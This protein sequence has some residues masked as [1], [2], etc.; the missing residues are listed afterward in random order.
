VS[1]ASAATAITPLSVLAANNH[2]AMQANYLGRDWAGAL[3]KGSIE[4]VRFHNVA[5]T[6]AEVRQEVARRGDMLGQFAPSLASDFNG[7]STTAES[8]VRNGRVRTLAAWVKPRTSDDVSNYEAVFDSGNER[9]GGAGS[10]LGL[11]AGK[12]VARLD[13]LGLWA[14]NVSATLNSWQHVALAFNGSTATLFVNG[15]QVATRSYTGPAADSA[16]SG[17][18]FR[19]G[20]SQT[21]EDTATRQ[22]F[23]GHILSARIFDRALT[24][25]QIQLDADGDGVVDPVELSFGTDP[26]NPLSTPPRYTVSGTV[27]DLAGTALA[28]A[29]VYFS[30]SPGAATTPAFTAIT[31]ASGQYSGSVTAGTWYVAAG[32]AAHNFSADRLVAVA[33]AAMAGIDFA[34][35]PNARI[36]GRVTRRSDGAAVTGASV[37]F[38]TSPGGTPVFTATTNASG[39]YT[40]PVFDGTWHVSAGGT[41]FYSAPEKVVVVSGGDVG[42]IGFALVGIGIPRPTD[43]LFSALSSSLPGS[44][45]TGDWPTY[46]P[47]AQTLTAMGSPAVEIFNGAKWVNSVYGEGD[48]FRQGTYSANVPINGAT[49]VVAVRP[50]RNTT[51]T[52]WTSVV[53]LFYN[54]LVLGVRN[55][56]G[57]I[58]VWRNGA[59]VTGS[60]GNAIP[61]GQATVLS[62]V[63]QPNGQYKVFANGT[64]VMD[65]TSTSTLTSLVPNVAGSYANAFNVGRNNPDGWTVFNGL[66]GD[67]FVYKVALTTT[68]R[69]QIEADLMA[70][71]VSPGNVITAS[72][73]AGGT[74]N[75]T[76][77]VLVPPGGGQTFT[78]APQP[79]Y[80]LST[81]TVNGTPQTPAGSFTFSNV[82]GAQ[83]ISATFVPSAIE[84]WRWAKFGA[85]WNNP[86]ISGDLVD[87]E[88]DGFVNLLEY[89][90]GADPHAAAA[91]P[92][93]RGGTVAG[94]LTITFQRVNTA[95]D[96]TLTVQG[97]DSPA[98]PWADLARSVNGAATTSLIG[99]VTTTETPAGLNTTVEVRD[100]YLLTDPLHPRR[101]LRLRVTR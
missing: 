29:T 77:A 49:I 20:Y 83:T 34:L 31:N 53:D 96:I 22:Y 46:Q 47:A 16:A 68:E 41:S 89:A 92:F 76:G 18:C 61:S 42:G 55:D 7:T 3:F 28:G 72:T 63:A 80:K 10:G 1:E 52:D 19:I 24:A 23:D 67:V 91:N 45:A 65:V 37:F 25:S 27:R 81:L 8:G 78:I 9:G 11:D 100:L 48:G 82:T 35:V 2:T 6:D 14:T 36:S 54:R 64:E 70:R 32:A 60:T 44:G 95:N 62:L 84:A 59:R 39:D 58:V 13:G 73:G 21:S 85:N 99:G 101:F 74:I 88:W 30:E 4:D 12:W 5:L 56:T 33:N 97:A 38:A 86:A 98:G 93:P 69:Q 75:P 15:A 71:F 57:Q 66:I 50:T 17:K 87:V 51:T 94:R 79:G 40:Q 43:L 26:I 90:L